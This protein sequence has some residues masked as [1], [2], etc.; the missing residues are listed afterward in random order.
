VVDIALKSSRT[1]HDTFLTSCDQ[2]GQVPACAA[3][4]LFCC[5]QQ[6][7][8]R[9]RLTME[10]IQK[11][12]LIKVAAGKMPTLPLTSPSGGPRD[13]NQPRKLKKKGDKSEKKTV[14][15]KGKHQ[16]KIISSD[17]PSS[18]KDES[19]VQVGEGSTVDTTKP[20]T[21]TSSQFLS[22]T[23]STNLPSS[24]ASSTSRVNTLSSTDSSSSEGPSTAIISDRDEAEL[25]EEGKGGSGRKLG[26]EEEELLLSGEESVPPKAGEE[27]PVQD[28]VMEG[29]EEVG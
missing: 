22:M 23:T 5:N 18:G 6:G 21:S 17:P 14:Q 16:V 19:E 25:L 26:E 7:G 4:L 1:F 8:Q 20:S 10:E 13:R 24:S 12:N 2:M 29:E 15:F 28:V 3:L 9:F 11:V 27:Q